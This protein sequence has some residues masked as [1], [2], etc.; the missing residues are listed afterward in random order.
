MK[1]GDNQEYLQL[2]IEYII[3]VGGQEDLRLF[4]KYSDGGSRILDQTK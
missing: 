3:E 2:F 1:Q 4:I